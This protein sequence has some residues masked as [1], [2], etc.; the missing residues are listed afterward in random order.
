MCVSHILIQIPVDGHLSCFHVLAIVNTASVN[1]RV[2]VSFWISILALFGSMPRSGIAGSYGSSIFSFLGNLL[3]CS[4][5][6]ALIYIPTNRVQ[7][8]GTTYSNVHVT[9]NWSFLSLIVM[10]E[11]TDSCIRAIK[12]DSTGRLHCELRGLQEMCLGSAAMATSGSPA[13]WFQHRPQW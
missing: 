7:R 2:R 3:L 12:S 8:R 6:A 10:P 5:V 4:I 1:I 11:Y 9:F 13:F